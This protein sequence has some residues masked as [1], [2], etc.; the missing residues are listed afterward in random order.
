M[1]NDEKKRDLYDRIHPSCGGI[2]LKHP[3]TFEVVQSNQC[4][5][6]STGIAWK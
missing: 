3:Y 6:G 5:Q 2:T 1:K 4:N